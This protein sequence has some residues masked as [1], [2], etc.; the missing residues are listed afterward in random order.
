[1]GLGLKQIHWILSKTRVKRVRICK[2][3]GRTLAKTVSHRKKKRLYLRN[4][5]LK[6]TV[7]D[8]NG[9]IRIV[10]GDKKGAVGAKE[11]HPWAVYTKKR[12]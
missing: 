4:E 8:L 11:K 3:V 5:K 2:G 12:I 6:A 1:M 9:L 10:L 7:G